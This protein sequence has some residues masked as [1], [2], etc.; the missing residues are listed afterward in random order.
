MTDVT[1]LSAITRGRDG[2]EKFRIGLTIVSP[3]Q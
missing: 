1:F 2:K 3:R